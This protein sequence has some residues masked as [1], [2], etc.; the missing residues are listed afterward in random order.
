M[1]GD[2]LFWTSDGSAVSRLIALATHGPFVHCSVDMGDGSDIGAHSDGGTQRRHVPD[3]RG[4]TK[5]S[6]HDA[7]AHQRPDLFPVEL[8][9]AITRGINFLLGELGNAYGW[10]NILNNV[11][12]YLRMPYRVTRL[13]RYDC[14]SLVT[15]YLSVVGYELGELGEEPDSVSPNDLARSLGL[16]AAGPQ[17]RK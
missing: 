14:S 5:V 17:V 16:L 10:C 8:T 7:L 15:R 4:I 1:R 6:V 13:N 11:L 9:G 12:S 3:D 2:V